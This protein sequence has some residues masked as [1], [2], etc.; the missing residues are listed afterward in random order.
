LSHPILECQVDV[1]RSARAA[2]KMPSGLEDAGG[3]DAPGSFNP[4]LGAVGHH[5]REAR[6][7]T[8]FF[9]GNSNSQFP[10]S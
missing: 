7:G 2:A 5:P 4:E 10:V 6:A 1:T 9:H 3:L 8:R